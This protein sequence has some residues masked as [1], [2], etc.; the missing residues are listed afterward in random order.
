MGLDIRLPMGAFFSLIGA[1]LALYGLVADRSIYE[2]SLGINV[3]LG[4]G[5]A[6]LAFGLVLLYLSRRGTGGSRPAEFDPEGR[7]IEEREYREGLES[8]NPVVHPPSDES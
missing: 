2:R 8:S 3:N 4:W 7:E 6:T 1:L 5:L